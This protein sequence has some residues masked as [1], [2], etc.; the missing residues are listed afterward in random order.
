MAIIPQPTLFSWHDI[1]ELGDL[2]RLVVVLD[3]LPDEALMH[4]L[5]D[6]RGRGRNEYPIRALWNS[7]LAGVVFQHPSIESLRRELA[8]N[9]QLREVCGFRGP[10]VPPASSYTRFL[11]QLMA[12]K[13]VLEAVFETLV[14]QLAAALPDLGQRTAIDGKAIATWAKKAPSKAGDDRRRDRDADW[15]AKTYRGVDKE[16][17]SWEKVVRWFGYKL[18]LMVDTTYELPLAWTLTQASVHD[19]TQAVPLIA[20][21][22]Q[23]HPRLRKRIALLAADKGYD[24]TEI[25]TKLWDQYHIKPVIDIRNAWK[26]PDSTRSLLAFSNATYNY[27]GDVFC[28]DPKTGQVHTMSNGGFEESRQSLKK[29]C[30]A[31]YAGVS[32]AGQDQ[33]PVAQGIRIPLD[34]DRRIFTPIDRTS[35]TWDREYAHRTAVERVNSR[36]D[37]SFGFELH[38]IRGM[39]KMQVRVGIALVVM[40]AMALGRVR[41]KRPQDMRRL[42]G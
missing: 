29:R 9:A 11:R 28:H 10:D 24:A 40:L 20:Q 22:D 4:T 35:Y 42:V 30:P 8:R 12:H 26:D 15:G 3:T 41:Q 19:S 1:T 6:A 13:T 21:L 16:G 33:C 27:R 39:Q 2:E 32:C 38:T 7:L 5:E 34:T 14:D 31:R 17:R 25:V 36:L 37:V 23:R 18:H